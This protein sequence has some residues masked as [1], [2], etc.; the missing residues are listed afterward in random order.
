VA[1]R[2]ARQAKLA[3]RSAN[4]TPGRLFHFIGARCHVGFG[5]SSAF[6]YHV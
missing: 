1:S 4:R 3:A 5:Q 2:L 6:V